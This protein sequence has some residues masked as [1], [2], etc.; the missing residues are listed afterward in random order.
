M[1]ACVYVAGQASMYDCCL[2]RWKLYLLGGCK[3]GLHSVYIVNWSTFLFL[4]TV[5]CWSHIDCCFWRMYKLHMF[6]SRWWNK[7]GELFYFVISGNYRWLSSD[8][9]WGLQSQV[10]EVDICIAV[11]TGFV[12]YSEFFVSLTVSLHRRAGS[13]WRVLFRLQ[14]D[15]SIHRLNAPY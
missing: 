5:M 3:N 11:S 4:V 9:Q 13:C 10:I 1:F 2:G 15:T 7:E 14:H 12:V 6:T 8:L